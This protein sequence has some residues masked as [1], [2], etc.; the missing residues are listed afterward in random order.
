MLKR[1][2]KCEH[3]YLVNDSFSPVSTMWARA[4]HIWLLLCWDKFLLYLFVERIF[5]VCF[6]LFFESWKGVEFC[7]CF[8]LYL[9]RLLCG[10]ILHSVNV[11][12]HI[13][14]YMLNHP[15]VLGINL[16]W[17]WCKILVMCYWIWYACSVWKIFTLILIRDIVL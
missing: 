13:K 3:L 16:T 6:F 15:C 4:F 1:N 5:V 17:S 14:F 8:F 10:F 12:Y 11:M 7:Q 9:V 2:G